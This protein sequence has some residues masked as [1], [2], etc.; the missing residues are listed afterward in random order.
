VFRVAGNDVLI[1]RTISGSVG[2]AEIY[3]MLKPKTPYVRKR[4]QPIA[5]AYLTE[6][7]PAGKI[8]DLPNPAAKYVKPLPFFGIP[9]QVRDVVLAPASSRTVSAHSAFASKLLPAD[10]TAR[11]AYTEY[12]SNLLWV[13]EV[14]LELDIRMFSMFNVPLTCPRA[15]V[16]YKASFTLK[17]PGLAENR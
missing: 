9:S 5:R 3:E 2:D 15:D 16:P 12:F 7:I 14:Q 8:E 11:K 13:E 17:V 10:F 4:I 6:V 1:S